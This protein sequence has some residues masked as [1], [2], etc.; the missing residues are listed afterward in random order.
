MVAAQ[1]TSLSPTCGNFAIIHPISFKY[2]RILETSDF[3]WTLQRSMGVHVQPR[4]IRKRNRR[5]V[6][7]WNSAL[8]SL[9][10]IFS[11]SRWTTLDPVSR[12]PAYMWLIR[13]CHSKMK[14]TAWPRLPPP[15]HPP[16]P[17]PAGSMTNIMRI[18]NGDNIGIMRCIEL[19]S[20]FPCPRQPLPLI[21]PLRS[22]LG[23]LVGAGSPVATSAVIRP[24]EVPV[25]RSRLPPVKP[26]PPGI[27]LYSRFPPGKSTMRRIFPPREI[28][29]RWFL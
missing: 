3:R 20:K 10:A 9:T 18:W 4:T 24:P 13:W 17:T 12:G 28:S 23:R 11:R 21:D 25:C 14:S 22:E 6:K 26:S 15:H 8:Q 27:L 19:N 7:S 29:Y 5:L 1:T 2:W 16:P